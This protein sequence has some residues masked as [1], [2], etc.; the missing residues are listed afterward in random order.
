MKPIRIAIIGFGKIAADQHVP[1]IAGNPRFALVASSSR[2]GE[3]AAQIFTDWREMLRT[4]EGLEAVA[5]TTPPSVRHEI[6]RECI[7]AGLH[8]LLEKPP[9]ATLSE[10]DIS[11]ASPKRR[12]RL[13]SLLALAA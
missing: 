3:G 5:I 8:V 6:A 11:R 2:S 9:A 4:V 12:A 1:S 13:S 7:L 10:I